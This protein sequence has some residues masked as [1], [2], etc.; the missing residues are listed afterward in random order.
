VEIDLDALRHNCQ[1]AQACCADPAVPGV[2]AVVKANG[3]GLGMVPVAEAMTGL[4]KG[5]AVANVTEALELRAGGVAGDVYLLG[6]ALPK[7]WDA[8]AGGGFIPA[9]SSGAEVSG[10]ALAAARAGTRLAVHVVID[11][12]M[13]RIGALPEE[14]EGLVRA[15]LASPHLILDSVA[16]HFPSAD[17]DAAATAGQA[18]RFAALIAGLDGQGLAVGQTQIAN[19]AGLAG[20]PQGPDSFARAGLMLYGVSPVVADQPRLRRVVEWKTRVGLVR[21]LPAGHGV[22][23]GGTFRTTAPTCVATLAVGYADG[24]PRQASGQ[25][26]AVLLGGVRCPV[27]GRVTMDQIMVDASSLGQR[28]EPGDIAVLVGGEGALEITAAELAAQGG[29]I[30]WDLFAGLG[31]RVRRCYLNCMRRSSSSSM[32]RTLGLG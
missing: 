31:P 30:A 15:V 25:G 12:G 26:A 10:Y 14:A 17:D 22:S 29:T 5:F 2:V 27:L 4:V 6:P 20:Y 23:Y 9:V 16:S 24:F 1:A 21:T 13:G 7:E 8:V 11:T 18:A 28:P 19:S 3:Y 32:L